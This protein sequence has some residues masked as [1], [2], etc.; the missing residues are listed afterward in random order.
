MLLIAEP[1]PTDGQ[2]K[3]LTYSAVCLDLQTP[4]QNEPPL[5]LGLN[6]NY[7]LPQELRLLPRGRPL[8]GE[9]VLASPPPSRPLTLPLHF[10]V[11]FFWTIAD[12]AFL[13]WVAIAVPPQQD[14]RPK[15]DG[16]GHKNAQYILQQQWMR[17]EMMPTQR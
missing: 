1:S 5:A 12:G 7:M 4:P 6:P 13:G 3:P 10:L 11:K 8:C 17:H 9:L 16:S 15:N 2:A 14:C